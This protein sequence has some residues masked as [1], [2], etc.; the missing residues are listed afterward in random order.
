M[1]FP[2][3][4][5]AFHFERDRI[6]ASPRIGV[7]CFAGLKKVQTVSANLVRNHAGGT[8]KMVTFH[9]A[10]L[11]RAICGTRLCQMTRLRKWERACGLDILTPHAP[12]QLVSWN[13]TE[14]L[15]RPG[16]GWE[17]L[18]Y[19]LQTGGASDC[20]NNIRNKGHSGPASLLR[21]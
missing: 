11:Y 16:G 18:G 19:L 8:A 14:Y 12:A 17:S 7:L 10:I 4:A 1:L 13:E 2:L 3:F 20:R 6:W 21:R 15:L 5:V 9:C